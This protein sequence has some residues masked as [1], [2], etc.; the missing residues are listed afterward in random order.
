LNASIFAEKGSYECSMNDKGESGMNTKIIKKMMGILVAWGVLFLGVVPGPAFAVSLDHYLSG[1]SE[2]LSHS[3]LTCDASSG[4]MLLADNS[5]RTGAG[6]TDSRVSMGK[7]HK[8]LGYATLGAALAAG[9]SGSD[10]G[11]H[12]G[13]GTAAAALAVA[14]CVTGFLEYSNYFD[15]SE[16]LSMHNIHIVLATLAT[17]GFV[18]TA[19][20]ALA[21]DDDGHA[22][23][24]ITSGV[25]M[26]VPVVVLHF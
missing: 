26:V 10:D 3:L 15:V 21:N 22:G 18:V 19:A 12:K 13:A 11:F 7:M 24:G 5:Q 20:D 25:L 1:V 8:Y 4:S 9:V 2:N 6:S 17:A 16:G 23:L 14:T